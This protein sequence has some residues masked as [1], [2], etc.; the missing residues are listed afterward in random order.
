MYIAIK[1]KLNINDFT[2][3]VAYIFTLVVRAFF[4]SI[5]ILLS[6]VFIIMS[7]SFVDSIYNLKNGNKKN[8][9]LDVYIIIT[10]SMIPTINVSDGIV[11]KRVNEDSLEIGDIITFSS[12]DVHYSG[13]TVTHRIVGKQVSSTGEYIYRTKGDNNIFED[14]A[15][16]N[17]DN[18]YGKVLLKIPKLGCLKKFVSSPHGFIISVITPIFFVIIYEGYRIYMVSKNN[19]ENLEVI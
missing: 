9:L 4:I 1:R 18:V 3:K 6:I 17:I 15:L 12:T 14:N 7:I 8:A 10:E 11:V 5:L 16:V 13:L 19:I 2:S